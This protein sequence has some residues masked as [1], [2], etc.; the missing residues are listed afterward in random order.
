MEFLKT[1]DKAI[2]EGKEPILLR[3]F[4]L[5][6][7]FLPEGYMWKLGTKCDRPR[8]MES[9]INKLCGT[10]YAYKFWQSY[11]DRYITKKDLFWIAEEG[12]NSVRLPLNARLLYSKVDNQL[13]INPEMFMRIDQLIDWC[14]ESRLY[15]ILDMHGA[16]GGQTGQ[17][18][19]DSEDDQPYL[20]MDRGF[21][22]EL[23]FLWKELAGRYKNEAVVAGYDLLNEPLPDM[24]KQYNKNVLPLYRR[25]IK[26]IREIDKKH[27]IVLEGVHWA[28]DFSIFADFTREEAT[29]NILLQF[30]KYWNNPDT[31]SM[32]EFL[33]LSD[34]LNIPLFM[35]EGGENNCDWYT[36]AFPLYEKLNISWSFWSFKKM[37][38]SN[39]PL[40]FPIPQGWTELIDYIDERCELEPDR[41]MAIFD[42]FL[43][44]I[45]KTY[46]NRAVISALKREL[47]LH[48]PCEAF[49]ECN[50]QSNRV[51]GAE[52]RLNE[53][54]S[55]VFEH[56]RKGKVDYKRMEGEEQPSEENLLIML[57]G[58]D[59]VAYQIQ[60]KNREIDLV[61]QAVGYGE[62]K[63]RR[64]G[65]ETTVCIDGKNAYATKIR[66]NSIEMEYLWL[67][68]ISGKIFL[69]Y[70]DLR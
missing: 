22:E 56:G 58:G 12:F 31:E 65:Q 45:S 68:C 34:R 37:D 61:M 51:I 66:N 35:G 10:Q 55:I 6:G 3:G 44:C 20:F 16:P 30:H 47:P 13:Q 11:M 4:G 25:V 14:R 57:K 7:W 29:D 48:I 50:I 38:N 2:Y 19:D 5:G 15:V 59:E 9:M 23:I 67:S 32:Q 46:V 18:I 8:R 42:D 17:N 60:G 41:A 53:P 28:T 63:I 70:L 27:M 40:T 33:D 69:D 26:E 43:E 62:L 64:S 49:Q 52:L 36:A 24:F 21:E 1:K 54:V 39:S